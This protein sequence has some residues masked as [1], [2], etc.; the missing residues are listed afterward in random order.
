MEYHTFITEATENMAGR[1]SGDIILHAFIAGILSFGATSLIYTYLYDEDVIKKNERIRELEK[2][3]EELEVAYAQEEERAD[4]AAEISNGMGSR[5]Q[6]LEG[7]LAET[8]KLL[9][10][11]SEMCAAV[12]KK[13]D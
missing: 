4:E 8:E 9:K 11:T 12:S 7:I 3:V 5:V 1:T 10:Q 13:N 6:E 2:K